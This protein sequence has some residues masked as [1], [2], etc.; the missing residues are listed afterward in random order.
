MRAFGRQIA[1]HYRRQR[2]LRAITIRY[3]LA[4]MNSLGKSKED[5]PRKATVPTSQPDPLSSG[6]PAARY[7]ISKSRDFPIHLEDWLI[8]H[9]GDP[10]LTVSVHGF[11]IYLF[12]K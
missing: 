2:L 5:V 8:K 11:L 9:D 7:Q 4:K 10:A 6:S 1:R 3:D 12:F